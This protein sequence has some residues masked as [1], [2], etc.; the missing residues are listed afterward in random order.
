MLPAYKKVKG[1]H[2]GAIL[3]RELSRRKLKSIQL[4]KSIQE[5]P[6]TINAIT[7]G[8]RGVNPNLSIKLGE[9][10][11]IDIEYFMLLQAAY[12]VSKSLSWEQNQLKGSL[13]GKIRA[14]IFWDTDI[15]QI[16]WVKNKRF[17]IQRVLERGNEEEIQELIQFY[18]LKA[19]KAEV[20]QIRGA[21]FLEEL[22]YR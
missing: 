16:D 4:A 9:Y 21:F 12:E 8:R 2:P 10:F 15:E 14:A 19:I 17:V 6:Q 5:H 18:S 13:S 1:I 11:G 7:K 20:A 22:L 3:K